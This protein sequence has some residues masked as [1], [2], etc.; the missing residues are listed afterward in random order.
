MRSDLVLSRREH[1]TGANIPTTVRRTLSFLCL[2]LML[3][4]VSVAFAGTIPVLIPHN[5]TNGVLVGPGFVD[6]VR[7]VVRTRTDVVYVVTA[8]DDPCQPTPIVG[9]G[10]IRAWKGIGAQP[11][12][13]LI[14]AVFQE[15]DIANHPVSA[16]TGSCLT[17]ST[18]MLLSPAIALD[19]SGIIHLAYIDGNNKNVYYQTFST[20]T[21]TWGAR[22][23]VGTNGNT[24]SGGSTLRTSGVG[25]A[26]DGNDVPHVIY[27]TAGS[28]N[29]LQYINNIGG[30]WS[31]PLT[32]ATG[33]NLI[34]PSM[35][36]ALDGTLHATW[37]DKSNATSP[38][39]KY[40][41]YA[42]GSWS[43][44]EIVSKGDNGVLP[45]GDDDQIPTIATDL[46]S[47][48][49]VLYLDGGVLKANDFVR[50]RYRTSGGVWTDNTPPGGVGGASN[51]A[52]TWF[53]HTPDNYV[54]ST[55]DD[56][57]FL[58]HD[59]NRSPGGYEYQIGGPGNPWSAYATADPRNNVN[60]KTGSP[61]VDGTA[62]VRFDPLRDNNPNIIDFIYFDQNDGSPGYRRHAV[63]YYKAIVLNAVNDV[64]PPSA[65]ITNPLN[66]AVATGTTTVSVSAFDD[67]GVTAVELYVDGTLNATLLPAP[68]NFAID[69]TLLV[70]G[71]HKLLAKAYDASGNVGIS[72]VVTVNVFNVP[73]SVISVQSN[74]GTFSNAVSGG[75]TFGSPNTAGNT[76]VVA[77]SWCCATGTITGSVTD[78]KGNVYATANGPR[79]LS[80]GL[81][82]QVWYAKNIKAGTNTVTLKLTSGLECC[83]ALHIIEYSGIASPSPLG[84]AVW[85]S[86]TGTALTSKNITSTQANELLIGFGSAANRISDAGLGFG[87]RDAAGN[88]L[89][90]EKI[91]TVAEN[92]A[93][94]MTQSA[95]GAWLDLATLFKIA[96]NGLRDVTPPSVPTGITAV[97][98]STTAIQ[99]TWT[100]S[101]DNEGVVGYQVLRNGVQIATPS[102]TLY[103][104]SGL[105]HST[106]YTYTIAAFDAAGNVS[107]QSAPVSATTP[108]PGPPTSISVVSGNNQTAPVGTSLPAPLTV[109]VV[110]QNNN[111]V[112]GATV[113]F[114]DSNAGGSF[115]P[116]PVIAD[117]SG[118][119]Q[120]S[121]TTSTKS[122]AVTIT[123]TSGGALATMSATATAGPAKNL[124][125]V[126]G[127]NQSASVFTTLPAALVV[128]VLDQYGNPVSGATVTFD[129]SGAGGSFS[130]SPVT[131]DTTGQAQTTYTAPRTIGTVTL[132]ATSGSLHVAMSA[133]VIAGPPA[134]VSVISGDNQAAPVSTPLPAPLVVL[135][136][137]QFNNVVSGAM[138]T[139]D[140]GNAGGSFA[141]SPVAT[142]ASGQAQTIYTTPN[143]SG[144]VTL[145]ATSSS[146]HASMTAN[147]AAGAPTTV[148]VVSGDGQTA[149]AGT[150]LPAALVVAVVDQFGNPVSGVTVTFDDGGAGGTFSASSAVTTDATGNATVT[151]T[152]PLTP[153][154]VNITASI[155]GGASVGFT[156]TAQ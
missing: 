125:V 102:S 61:G 149:S 80:N 71:S 6:I 116:S 19:S 20:L 105:T 150:V 47:L 107:A 4:A 51:P 128:S 50:M 2:A 142:D 124:S 53:A 25:L 41:H 49:H 132:N 146:A 56:W 40:A 79:A 28:A 68:Y 18:S 127:N 33:S 133:A 8:D 108:A 11:S 114:D 119:A 89:V 72:N 26:L 122:G 37:L 29:S 5:D 104:D 136:V 135:V 3:S 101:T 113:T 115:S 143:K 45:N 148:S 31:T 27:A 110:D 21:D 76:I 69:T 112:P 152:L 10:V 42:F 121:Y 97:P 1:A 35:V 82:A 24:F 38:I 23:L 62:S 83:S 39:I 9:P 36:T 85:S 84:G 103:N 151:Y 141:P 88:D 70:D 32:V 65:S 144:T 92:Y 54:S 52:G 48:P 153:G 75:V 78:T 57:V 73:P 13:P 91:A 7:Q 130:P 131:T 155:T 126:S 22:T 96:P 60:K 100:P 58:G 63:I 95:S 15:Q 120:T 43:A 87:I 139:F 147:V 46:N 129:D 118:Q 12:N 137:D 140:D 16:G 156:E 17:S 59:V 90:E 93:T 154:T 145:T 74:G 81:H 14:P 44:P 98:T 30:I 138:V 94:L 106:P 134:G 111:L 117:T 64:Q 123:A 66:N 86:G 67:V 99:L 77:G 34:H 55:G 109:S